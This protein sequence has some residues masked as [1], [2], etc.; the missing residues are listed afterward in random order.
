MPT[1]RKERLEKSIQ[2]IVA[3]SLIRDIKDPRI[4]FVTVTE[5]ELNRDKSV[6]S[7]YVSVFG[8]EKEKK[9][10][11]AGLVS[12]S[13]FIQ[14][15]VGKNIRMRNTPKIRFYL[16]KSIEEGTEMIGLLNRLEE[17]RP[18]EDSEISG[19]NDTEEPGTDKI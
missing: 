10:S 13:G 7:V 11:M 4:G 16:D 8:S 12:A 5:V 17:E 9:S 6:A 19:L 1:Y 2:R 3:E 18:K 15:K 14:F